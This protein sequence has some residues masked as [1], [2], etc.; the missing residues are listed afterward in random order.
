MDFYIPASERFID[1]LKYN[2]DNYVAKTSLYLQNTLF[3]NLNENERP[4]IA[5]ISNNSSDYMFYGLSLMLLNIVPLHLSTRL[6]EASYLHLLK[7]GK[8]SGILVSDEF[9]DI[10]LALKTKLEHKVELIEMENLDYVSM[11]SNELNDS[12][13]ENMSKFATFTNQGNE[14]AYY[15]HSTGSTSLYPK[16]ISIANK[17]L[18]S[19]TSRA[20]T[21][22]PVYPIPESRL[23]PLPLYHTGGQLFN[24]HMPIR[25]CQH[26]I[27]PPNIKGEILSGSIILELLNCV[28]FDIIKWLP[29]LLIE[30][31]EHCNAIPY[32]LGWA[33][34]INWGGLSEIG[35]A[36]LP[37]E[38]ISKF[39][40]N[41]QKF[42][43]YFGSSEVGILGYS[44][45]VS[46]VEGCRFI[47]FPND[48][49]F[50]MS[51]YDKDQGIY[52]LVVKKEEK[53][54]FCSE[55]DYKTKDL[56]KVHSWE[57]RAVAEYHSRCDDV[58]VHVTGEK[59]NPLPMENTLNKSPLIQCSAILGKNHTLNRALIQLNW[60]E[61]ELTGWDKSINLINEQVDLVNK[62]SPSHSRLMPNC[63]HILDKGQELLVTIKGNIIRQANYNLYKHMMDDFK[64]DNV[65][66]PANTASKLDLIAEL[67][68]KALNLPQQIDT[69]NDFFALGM[70]SLSALV[71]VKK[72]QQLFPL[73]TLNVSLVYK[74]KTVL[75]LMKYLEDTLEVLEDTV[76]S[77]QSRV[78]AMILK[79]I[80]RFS[81]Y[82]TAKAIE[83]NRRVVLVVGSNGSLA[84]NLIHSLL[85][86]SD[87]DK[88]IGII[89]GAEFSDKSNHQVNI[90]REKGLFIHQR[91]LHKLQCFSADMHL[92]SFNLPASVYQDIC[93]NVTE[94]TQVGWRM[95]FLNSLE[96]F[97]DC[98]ETTSNLLEFCLQNPKNPK[99]FNF[100]S[101]IAPTVPTYKI[102]YNGIIPE[103]PTSGKIT[104]LNSCTGYGLSKLV[105]EQICYQVA[106]TKNLPVN[107][108]RVGELSGD[109]SL[110][111]WNV[112]E[113]LPLLIRAIIKLKV[114]PN[115]SSKSI[116]WVP[117]DLA[118][119][120]LADLG[121]FKIQNPELYTIVNPQKSEWK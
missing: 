53:G 114:Y 65:L 9:S 39:L 29:K 90:M 109:Q 87:I 56:F 66:T 79:Y 111:Q 80:Q 105:S 57:P 28:K 84:C 58:L 110:G 31:V 113:F 7:L 1:L 106:K 46:K 103:T 99:I 48:F 117:I 27:A 6:N 108:F 104:N 36:A 70:D 15:V 85:H 47:R 12:E 23:S 35:G 63:V 40:E 17:V 95:N 89:R 4:V 92:S 60:R 3:A 86:R 93:D 43:F 96:D 26:I 72:L 118:A 76:E 98:I 64:A 88:V 82:N 32:E 2:S 50:F 83:L 61:V 73:T 78:D 68:T 115:L 33:K 59:T 21:D 18:F 45:V 119:K 19:Q 25:W 81:N 121:H 74:L 5:I 102:E 94:V 62:S 44:Q 71:V 24:L 55:D 11:L 10:G 67:V 112:K 8:A 30:F 34:L 16:L 77:I 116:S 69:N 22:T 75:N 20:L 54:L 42:R 38:Y 91:V 49:K 52:E 14:L 41:G 13:I 101:T 107:V 97:E 37:S 51:P 120:S 100:I